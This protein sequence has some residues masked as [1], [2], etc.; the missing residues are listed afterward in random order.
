[1][2]YYLHEL[3]DYF[4]ALRLFEAQTFRVAGACVSAFLLCLLLGNRVILKLISLKAGQPIRQASEVHKLAELHGGKGGTPTMGGILLIGA[5]IVSTLLWA[6][7]DNP[8]IWATLFVGAGMAALGFVDDYLKVTK[9]TSE[10]VSSKMKLLV[11]L[12]IAILAIHF[13]SV[14]AETAAHMK[15]LYVPF[16][17]DPVINDMGWFAYVFMAVVIV[18]CSNA[19][20]LTDGLDGL[21]TGCMISTAMAYALFTYIAGHAVAANYLLLPHLEYVGELTVICAA[22][23]GAGLGFMWFNCHPAQVFMG[24]TGS[25]AIGGLLAMVAICAKQ[26]ILLVIVGGVFVLEAL[27]VILQV[28]SFKLTGKRIFK[29]A[30]IHHHFELMGWKES[31]VITRFW[32][33]SIMFAMLG[34]VTLKIR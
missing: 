21:A 9:K 2:L 4:S 17:K 33:I 1:M 13:L 23:V 15:Q 24:D 14:H 22:L 27:S 29:M 19:V 16:F 34:M 6:R 31:K 7:L 18:G 28:L 20:N 12:V 25:L 8:M 32:I 10:G 5:V 3:S 30:P 26:E 11:Q